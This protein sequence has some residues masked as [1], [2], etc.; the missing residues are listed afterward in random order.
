LGMY[1]PGFF[2]GSLIQRYGPRVICSGAIV[3]YAVALVLM[4][5]SKEEE[6]GKYSI[7]TWTLGMILLGMG[8][9][10]GFTSATVWLTELYKSP[11]RSHLKT[12]LQAANDCLM[13]GLAGGW[14]FSA[15][16]IFDAGGSGLDGWKLLNFVVVGLLAFTTIILLVN[17]RLESMA[18]TA[19]AGSTSTIEKQVS[20]DSDASHEIGQTTVIIQESTDVEMV[21]ESTDVESA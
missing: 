18:T 6:D 16:Y 13:F 5:V 2:T 8:W 10:F 3:L 15:S 4:L 21:Q 9:N 19:A 1:A 17:Y 20:V 12:P 7:V 11:S 14:I